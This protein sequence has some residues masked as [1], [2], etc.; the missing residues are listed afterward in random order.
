MKAI[1]IRND[2]EKIVTE[3]GEN[4]WFISQSGTYDDTDYDDATYTETGSIQTKAFIKPVDGEYDKKF[5]LEGT[6]VIT[7]LKLFVPSGTSIDELTKIKRTN[8]DIYSI[9]NVSNIMLEGKNVFKK[10]FI[11][12]LTI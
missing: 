12:Y 7:D 1:D 2:L 8:G 3:Y 6:A 4:C 9:L 5:L 10:A 11:R